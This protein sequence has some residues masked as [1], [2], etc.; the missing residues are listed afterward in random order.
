MGGERSKGKSN[1][2]KANE[3][4]K[5]VL[6]EILSSIVDEPKNLT[7]DEK[8]ENGTIYFTVNLP[9][10]EMGRVIGK[11]GRII[12]AL[13][14]VMKIPAIKQGKRINISLNENSLQ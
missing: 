13:R 11:Q 1:R 9:K 4:M 12:R 5:D 10:E 7:I 6:L 2:L 8:E 14:N 3:N